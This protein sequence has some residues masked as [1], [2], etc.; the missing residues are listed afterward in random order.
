[1]LDK[2]LRALSIAR[3]TET[4]IVV[5]HLAKQ[6]VDYVAD[7][8]N[9]NMSIQIAFQKE[10]LGTADALFSAVEFL[11]EPC[12]VLAGDYALQENF[13]L[14]LKRFYQAGHADLVVS[15]KEIPREEAR[16]RSSIQL[17]EEDRILQILEK[18]TQV[19]VSDTIGASL[20]YIVPPDIKQFL[21]HAP[22]SQRGEYEL[23]ELIN[24]MIGCGFA[25]S[26]HISRIG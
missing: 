18:P 9:W 23:P 20:I 13:L 5:N 6:I 25:A 12:F 1:M 16:H 4:C 8:R 26:A 2:I 17:G 10:T 21:Q 14:D 19:T 7:G 11:I 15:M 24:L 3:V 22:L